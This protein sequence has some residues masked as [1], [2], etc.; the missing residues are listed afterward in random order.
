MPRWLA[1]A[2]EI[3]RLLPGAMTAALRRRF[4]GDAA[5]RGVDDAAREAYERRIRAAE[6]VA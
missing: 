6:L 2:P 3:E 1:R 5:L 4:G